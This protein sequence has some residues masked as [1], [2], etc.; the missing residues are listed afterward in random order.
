MKSSGFV[1]VLVLTLIVAVGTFFPGTGAVPFFV[2]TWWFKA[3]GVALFIANFG[4]L[5][6]GLARR[7]WAPFVCQLGVD[8]V[9]VLC[10]PGK[11]RAFGEAGLVGLLSRAVLFSF[12]GAAADDEAAVGHVAEDQV[13][14][15]VSPGA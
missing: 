14:A 5:I 13:A 3:L 4:A 7:A 9:L 2:T 1:L 11:A 10:P 6:M 15:Q 8:W 12:A